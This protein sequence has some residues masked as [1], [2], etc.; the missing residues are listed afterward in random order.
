[1]KR[2]NSDRHMDIDRGK[3]CPSFDSYMLQGQ[4][5]IWTDSH[6]I[7]YEWPYLKKKILWEFII[8]SASDSLCYV[9]TGFVFW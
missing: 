9:K 2:K 7:I 5:R 1:M 4:G 3:K 6:C 8:V